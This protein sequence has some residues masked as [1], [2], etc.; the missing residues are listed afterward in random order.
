MVKR[1]TGPFWDASHHTPARKQE[2]DRLKLN[3]PRDKDNADLRHPPPSL[4]PD[5]A[6]N[7]AARGAIG[8][9][10]DLPTPEHHKAK[11]D[12]SHKA[13]GD[14]KRTFKPIARGLS[15]KDFDHDR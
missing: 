15:A 13:P 12:R 7:R 14:L 11:E 2:L 6:T 4:T 10:R 5:G 8:T 3:P 9:K 1:P